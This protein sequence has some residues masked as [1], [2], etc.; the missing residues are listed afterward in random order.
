LIVTKAPVPA[1]IVA[2]TD[3]VAVVIVPV[4]GVMITGVVLI[5]DWSEA[6]TTG[7]ELALVC[8]PF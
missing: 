7:C 4:A 6:I 8:C 1:P 5:A 2:V 3:E